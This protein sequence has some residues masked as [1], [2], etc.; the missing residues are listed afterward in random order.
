MLF[1][2]KFTVAGALVGLL[3]LAS[4]GLLLRHLLGNSVPPLVLTVEAARTGLVVCC[5]VLLSDAL[6]HGTLW[7]LW[8]KPY[9]RAYHDLAAVFRGQSALAILIGA[10]MAGIGEE[11]VFRGLSTSPWFLFPAAVVFGLLHH[12][13][14][15][16]R[17]FTLWFVWEGILFAIAMFVTGELV[18]TMTAHFLHDL[19]GFLAFRFENRSLTT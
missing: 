13:G 3:V 19:L 14:G 10:L 2:L 15:S 9:R 11:M 12:L 1:R 6:V 18:A 8:G 5:A 4:L 7:L 16:L 17:G